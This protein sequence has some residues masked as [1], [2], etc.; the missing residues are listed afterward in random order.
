MAKNSN[1]YNMNAR[2]KPNDD[3][4]NYVLNQIYLAIKDNCMSNKIQEVVIKYKAL[5][6]ED[7][8]QY[9]EASMFLKE[10][11]IIENCRTYSSGQEDIYAINNHDKDEILFIKEAY[12]L[13][14]KILVKYLIENSILP[15]YTL[16]LNK[17]RQL[18]LNDQFI[19]VTPQ[20]NSDNFYT[21][22]YILKNPGKIITKENLP[23]L[24]KLCRRFHTF[25]EQVIKEPELIKVFFPDVSKDKLKFRNDVKESDLK[26]EK[27]KEKNIIKYV[28]GLN[29]VS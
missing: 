14:P 3:S 28:K 18:I 24:K 10:N 11:K 25:L 29:S 27:I 22:E 17:K 8:V 26:N 6:F 21:I 7:L 4:L 13:K 16:S 2:I 15:K 20:F 5:S 9:T 19:L 23:P 1:I 12:E